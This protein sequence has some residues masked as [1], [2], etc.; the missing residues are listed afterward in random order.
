[1]PSH[2]KSCQVMVSR[3]KSAEFRG[4]RE[5]FIHTHNFVCYLLNEIRKIRVNLKNIFIKNAFFIKNGEK[6]EK[7]G[8]KAEEKRR[9]NGG[10]PR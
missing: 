4:Q 2:G 10:I 3:A 7:N 6:T 5:G 1:M 8:G 9:N